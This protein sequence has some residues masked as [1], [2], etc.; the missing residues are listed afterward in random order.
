MEKRPAAPISSEPRPAKAMAKARERALKFDDPRSFP[1]AKAA[2]SVDKRAAKAGGGAFYPDFEGGALITDYLL[3]QC[4]EAIAAVFPSNTRVLFPDSI[5]N[6]VDHV[7]SGTRTEKKRSFVNGGARIGKGESFLAALHVCGDHWVLLWC[8]PKVIK[9]YDS[10]RS[11][12]GKAVKFA[13]VL[14]T[15]PGFEEAVIV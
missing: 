9:V 5:R 6:I 14:A 13:Q 3:G 4:L 15:V 10:L 7:G 2:A 8:T 11:H 1:P 12:N